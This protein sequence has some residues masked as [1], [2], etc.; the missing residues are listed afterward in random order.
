MDVGRVINFSAKPISNDTIEYFSLCSNNIFLFFFFRLLSFILPFIN[1][2]DIAAIV[3][4]IAVD[5][6]ILLIFYSCKKILNIKYVFFAYFITILL[7]GFMGWIIC[8]YSDTLALPFTILLFYINICL[9]K[10]ESKKQK[11]IYSIIGLFVSFIGYLV[12][13]TVIIVMIAIF[14]IN[15]I[16]NINHGKKLL[17]KISEIFIYI[18]IFLLL[19]KLWITFVTNQNIVKVDITK[20]APYTHFIMMGMNSNTYGGWNYYDQLFTAS[21]STQELKKKNNILEIKR[22]L[23]DFGISGY[24]SYAF[25]KIR[26][27]T[28]EGTFY[29]GGE[30]TFANFDNCN[31]FLKNVYYTNGTHYDVY[32]YFFQGIWIL[33]MF[34]ILLNFCNINYSYHQNIIFMTIFGILLFLVI[35]EGRSRYLILYLPFFT[36]CS[37]YGIEN[38]QKFKDNLKK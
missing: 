9:N 2:W 36:I 26:W 10:T 34:L 38:F 17:S 29:W 4:I 18:I 35:F 22:R 16:S 21:F 5:L 32:K 24:S 7:F 37:T 3:N 12:K 8:P 20:S 25:R 1:I 14:V 27:I 23:N 11:R 19:N 13:P 15:I 33:I 6:C 28:S 30:G 31:N